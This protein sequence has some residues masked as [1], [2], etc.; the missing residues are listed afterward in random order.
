M[1][2]AWSAASDR[3]CC[4]LLL[5][6]YAR[7]P[8]TLFSIALLAR[9]QFRGS[10]ELD[11]QPDVLPVRS[12]TWQFVFCVTM[13]HLFRSSSP[14]SS[15]PVRS[16]S[17]GRRTRSDSAASARW[18]FSIYTRQGVQFFLAPSRALV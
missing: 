11:G 10:L 18:I 9:R 8:S 4:D 1:D 6:A 12:P 17:P 13:S 2:G 16:L 5:R 7:S 3:R 15:L 14:S